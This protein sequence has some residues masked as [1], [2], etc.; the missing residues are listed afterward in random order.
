MK[1]DFQVRCLTL[2][3]VL[4][5][6]QGWCIVPAF[7]Q[8]SS[9]APNDVWQMQES[10][11]KA[12]LRGI[13]AVSEDVCWASGAEGTVLRTTDGGK[14]W[15]KVGP[16]AAEAMDFRDIHAW[17]ADN[18]II[19]SAG[20][21]DRLYRT[22]DGGKTWQ[23]VFEHEQPDAFL[24]GIVFAANGID[25]WLMGDPL[26]NKLT[27]ANTTDG[28]RTWTLIDSQITPAMNDDIGGFAASGTNLTLV[29]D[30]EL[31]IGLGGR[32]SPDGMAQVVRSGDQGKTWTVEITPMPANESSGIFSI[33]A[34]GKN[35]EHAVAVGGDYLKPD[36]PDGTCMI[37]RDGAKSWQLLT[38]NGPSGYRSIVVAA[39][40]PTGLLLIAAGPNGTDISSDNG[41]NWSRTSDGGFH[42]MSFVPG[43]QTGW[44]A[45]ADGR[46]AKW[47]GR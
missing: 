27:I 43:T 29:N 4:T 5:A 12:S 41:Q 28:G 37:S 33:Q 21:L 23:L 42:T 11:C 38:E 45:G 39:A 44:A 6:A 14:T 32:G 13:C 24:D 2:L 30:G 17:D 19:M 26:E 40:T 47:I 16:D 20:E 9:V 34:F 1:R 18:A 35:N 10:G 36:S 3:F 31:L 46:I 15:N 8:P 25:G 22:E 7:A